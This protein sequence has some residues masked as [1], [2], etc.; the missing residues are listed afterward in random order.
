M[1]NSPC[2]GQE[3]AERAFPVICNPVSCQAVQS[4]GKS[5]GD[6]KRD[7]NIGELTVERA[8]RG[9]FYLVIPLRP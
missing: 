2:I 9:K 7:F 6:V 8:M 5:G 3:V 1:Q 4:N